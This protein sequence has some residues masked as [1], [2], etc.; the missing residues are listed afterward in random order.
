[1]Q[2]DALLTDW[3]AAADIHKQAAA[4]LV[5]EY[6]SA[7][8]PFQTYLAGLAD[9]QLDLLAASPALKGAFETVGKPFS[10]AGHEAMPYTT[11]VFGRAV[12]LEK[13]AR[14]LQTSL[15]SLGATDTLADILNNL[16]SLHS[17]ARTIAAPTFGVYF[18]AMRKTALGKGAV[19]AT[20]AKPTPHLSPWPNPT[21]TADVVR[22]S[23]ALGADPTGKDYIL[24]AYRLQPGNAPRAPTTASP[25]WTYQRW[26]RPNPAAAADLHGWT[27]PLAAGLARQPEIVH[28][29]ENGGSEIVFPI[30]I[31]SA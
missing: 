8:N 5:G 18:D 22:S 20:F 9:R 13:F 4:N 24:F 11:A 28:L 19:F 12:L 29:E 21:P 6:G 15:D 2:L 17:T 31:A 25:G 10:L 3:Q 1:M 27:E 26:F 16:R 30:H 7:A 14:Y 23:I